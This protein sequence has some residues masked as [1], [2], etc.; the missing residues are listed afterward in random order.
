MGMGTK[1]LLLPAGEDPESFLAALAGRLGLDGGAASRSDRTYLDTFDGRL[2]AR[3][4]RLSVGRNGSRDGAEAA[5]LEDASGAQVTAEPATRAGGARFVDELPPGV[6]R[7]RVAGAVTPRVLRP[8]ARV[9]ATARQFNVLNGERKTVARIELVEPVAV[10][11]SA[12]AHAL[13]S[14]LILREVR[15]YAGAFARTERVLA[16][17]L[18][19]VPAEVDVLEEALIATGRPVG[20]VSSALDMKLDRDASAGLAFTTVFGRLLVII[21]ANVPGVLDDT[22]VEFL[23]DLR[24]AVRRTR[25]LVKQ[26]APVLPLDIAAQLRAEF[27]WVQQVTGPTRDLDVHIVDL[28][29]ERAFLPELAA[30]HLDPV[31]NTV[32]AR[33][34]KEFRQMVRALRSD[35]FARLRSD[36]NALV[37]SG[38]GPEGGPVARL[39]IVSVASRRV[40]KLYDRMVKSVSTIDAHTPD[41][42]LHDLR[43]QGKELRYVLEMF[44]SVLP[45]DVLQPLLSSL[46]GLQDRLGE[47]NDR[48]V[49][50]AF[51]WQVS[52]ELPPGEGWGP[53]LV[54]AG[55]IVER[56]HREQAAARDRLPER[57]AVFASKDMRQMVQ[58]LKA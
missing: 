58:R 4:W 27:A 21:E 34:Q 41:E 54:A 43:K 44:G 39:P 18:G 10:D 7:D 9:R 49:Q 19:L 42:A 38:I 5:T 11:R 45:A 26:L 52:H 29:T 46:K 24:V 47:F 23:H 8:V 2:Y 6:L 55:V 15:G 37:V 32:A 36:G 50:A 30:S 35:R 14:R 48:H 25:S 22:D 31:A 16:A 1:Q 57:F 13:R 33:R 56:L 17:E 40:A 51:L 53:A 12:K 28:A 3:G 20:G